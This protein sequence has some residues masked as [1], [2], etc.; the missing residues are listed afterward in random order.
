[1]HANQ[2]SN[3]HLLMQ[4]R[5]FAIKWI[6]I[7]APLHCLVRNFETLKDTFVETV[8]AQQEFVHAL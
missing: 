2:S 8:L 4:V 5:L 3:L 6:D 7:G 1:M